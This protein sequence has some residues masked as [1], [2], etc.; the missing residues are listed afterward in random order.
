M[1]S[2][3]VY[4]GGSILCHVLRMKKPRSSLHTLRPC[5][6]SKEEIANIDTSNTVFYLIYFFIFSLCLLLNDASI[7]YH[8]EALKIAWVTSSPSD[9][10][11]GKP[12]DLACYFSGWPLPDEVNWYK[13]GERI[14]SGAKGIVHSEDEQWKNGEKTLR[15]TLHLPPGR[16]EQEGFYKCSARNSIPSN[17]SYEIQMIY[18]CK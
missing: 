1:S 13:D 14:T 8:L 15:S 9:I 12:V 5:K 3:L 6:N 11:E 4:Y 2:F 7:S 16:E 17:A 10:I 18:Q